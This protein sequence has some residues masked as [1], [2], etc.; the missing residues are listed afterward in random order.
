[1]FIICFLHIKS[2]IA[3]ELSTCFQVGQSLNKNRFQIQLA[4]TFSHHDW[5]VSYVHSM[6][7]CPI[8]LIRISKDKMCSVMTSI[9]KRMGASSLCIKKVTIST[10][11]RCIYVWISWLC[12]YVVVVG[13]EQQENLHSR[14]Q[15]AKHGPAEAL[16]RSLLILEGYI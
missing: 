16:G 12:S 6:I 7:C 11:D 5:N 8:F 3:L 4:P 2:L 10:R 15:I 14:A 1:M 9:S 13:V